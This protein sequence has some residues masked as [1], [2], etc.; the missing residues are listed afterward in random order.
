MPLWSKT[1]TDTK[2]G[3][4]QFLKG[5]RFEQEVKANANGWVREKT[6]TDMHGNTRVKTEMLVPIRGLANSTNLGTATISSVKFTSKT[7]AASTA[8]TLKVSWNET[9]KV[10]SGSPT[11]TLLVANTSNNAVPATITATYNGQGNNTNTLTFSLTTF[12]NAATYTI[13]SA[14]IGDGAGIR[15]AAANTAA[16]LTIPSNYTGANSSIGVMTVTV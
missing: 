12:S 4:P 5:S 8:K 13:K 1:D 16:D 10:I 3:A 9:V 11:L 14:T 7:G 6:Y 15:D 2:S